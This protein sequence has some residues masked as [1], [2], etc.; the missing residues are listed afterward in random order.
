M[1]RIIKQR[2]RKLIEEYAL[3]FTLKEEPS[4]GYSFE[5]DKEGR[6]TKELTELQQGS[7]KIAQDREKYNPGVV[8]DYSRYYTEPAVLECHC[9]AH[10]TL[11]DPHENGCGSCERAYNLYGQEVIAGY[12][13]MDAKL[14]GVAWDEDDL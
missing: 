4:A 9:G 11:S 3:V 6:V 12:D 2:E 7:W 8:H 10:V 13:R 14:D 5:C 1:K